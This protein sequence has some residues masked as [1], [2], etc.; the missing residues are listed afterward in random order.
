[1]GVMGCGPN[2][3]ARACG[4]PCTAPRLLSLPPAC[5]IRSAA[6]ACTLSGPAQVSA[7]LTPAAALPAHKTLGIPDAQ[8]LKGRRVHTARERAPCTGF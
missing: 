6:N 3:L 8:P 2:P 1:M 4:T 7:F 5:S